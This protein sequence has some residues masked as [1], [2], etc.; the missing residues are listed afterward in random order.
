MIREMGNDFFLYG[1]VN[2][3]TG[4]G[5]I[6]LSSNMIRLASTAGRDLSV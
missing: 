2:D 5:I 4:Q 1:D 6:N 3:T